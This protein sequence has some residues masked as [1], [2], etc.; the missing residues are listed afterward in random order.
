MSRGTV[1][2]LTPAEIVTRARFLAG[3]VGGEA[4]DEYVLF[5]LPECPV[6]YYRL[7]GKHDG[8]PAY[9]GG[10]D[11][12][13][14]S[15]ADLWSKKGSTFVNVTSDCMGG[16][17]WCSG[18]DRY[19]PQRMPASIRY[20]GWYNTDSMLMD[21]RG[22]AA[23]FIDVGRPQLGSMITCAS[24][25]PGH[26][27]GHVGIVVDVPAEWDPSKRGC[28]EAIGVVDVAGRKGRANMRTTGRGWYGT[29]ARFLRSVMG[30]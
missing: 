17:A 25:T 6:I 2:P 28:W 10:K 26:R 21:A 4:L 24:K 14:S 13:A 27:V 18:F 3:E 11:P 8:Y 20:K 30:P 19:Q 29:G 5:P 15:P 7:N 1:V 22:P 16:A 9:N 12:M 23:C